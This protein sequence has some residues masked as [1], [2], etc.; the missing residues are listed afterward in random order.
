[1][2]QISTEETVTQQDKTRIRTQRLRDLEQDE[3]ERKLQLKA[4]SELSL[5]ISNLKSMHSSDPTQGFGQGY[6]SMADK[7]QKHETL[8]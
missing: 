8:F 1:M 6:E 2:N 3:E 5:M 7:M 4:V